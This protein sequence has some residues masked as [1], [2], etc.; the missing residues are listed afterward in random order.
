[1]TEWILLYS[2]RTHF[3]ES[4]WAI[5][6]CTSVWLLGEP[7][8]WNYMKCWVQNLIY[9]LNCYYITQATVILTSRGV[10]KDKLPSNWDPHNWESISHNYLRLITFN[11]ASVPNISRSFRKRAESIVDLGLYAWQSDVM[12]Q[13]WISYHS[14]YVSS[15]LQWMTISSSI[16]VSKAYNKR[17]VRLTKEIVLSFENV[18][19]ERLNS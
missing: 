19:H 6:K 4:I 7:L 14:Q 10:Q 11:S 18:P 17:M 12:W 8:K 13:V 5:H 2:F 3:L 16:G 9:V 15:T 1:M